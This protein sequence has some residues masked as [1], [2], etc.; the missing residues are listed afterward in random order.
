VLALGALLAVELL[1]VELLAVALLA[2]LQRA[3]GATQ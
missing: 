1:A 2:A 3:S